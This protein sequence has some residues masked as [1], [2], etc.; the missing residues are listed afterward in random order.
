MHFTF[1]L[2]A[3]MAAAP[4]P[5]IVPPGEHHFASY[6]K[7]YKAAQVLDRPMLVVLNPAG[8][9]Q[10]QPVSFTEL[11]GTQERRDL[12]GNYVV[13]VIDTSTEHGQVVHDLFG[14]PQLPRVVVIDRDQKYQIF[15]TSE[16]LYGQLWTRILTT[17][18]DGQYVPVRQ[19]AVSQP[20][21][22]HRPAYYLE[23]FS[24]PSCRR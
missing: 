17:Y 20:V 8:S 11:T 15:Q 18:K 2:L 22:E 5:A 14:S 12:L 19:A 10:V 7:A 9:A 21:Y 1:A 16:P 6:T 13:A 4:E 23:Q 24:C 3:V